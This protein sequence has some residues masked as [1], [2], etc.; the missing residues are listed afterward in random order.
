VTPANL[1]G[2]V[3]LTV[4]REQVQLQAVENAED[5]HTTAYERRWLNV[6]LGGR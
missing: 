2:T 1:G 4:Q 6:P 3:T 5:G